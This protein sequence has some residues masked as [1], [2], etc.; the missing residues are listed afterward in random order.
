[1]KNHSEDCD[2]DPHNHCNVCG[3]GIRYGERCVDCGRKVMGYDSKP[4]PTQIKV[5]VVYDLDN[6]ECFDEAV[7]ALKYDY[8]PMEG[9]TERIS[10]AKWSV[11]ATS[12]H[13]GRY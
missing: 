8:S 1:M 4:V 5:I 6:P 13:V 3:E 9:R 10:S 2:D 12:Y 7:Q 11:Q